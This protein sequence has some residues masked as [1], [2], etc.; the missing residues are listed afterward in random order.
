MNY[1]ALFFGAFVVSVLQVVFSSILFG[2]KIILEVSLVLSIYAAFR[3]P[4]RKGVFFSLL[5]GLFLDSSV[6]SPTGLSTF[7]H[8]LIFLA[9][10]F[11]SS[12]VFK[13]RSLFILIFVMV[14]AILEGA[15]VLAFYKLTL[16]VGSFSY[17][18]T[19]IPQAL[20]MGLLAPV[21]FLV[22]NKLL[23]D[24]KEKESDQGE[25]ILHVTRL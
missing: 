7:T 15:V 13:E 23:P 20:I 2:G 5:L 6:G 12:Q 16:G 1:P 3:F 8:F 14:A 9:A 24:R 18:L 4:F 19:I 10:R 22:L 21:I 11:I 17:F 25:T